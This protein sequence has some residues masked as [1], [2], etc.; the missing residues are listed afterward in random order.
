MATVL[1]V[2]EL[3]TDLGHLSQLRLAIEVALQEGHTV[4]LAARELHR[5][6]EVMGD[7]P[8]TYLQAPFK[9]NQ[10]QRGQ[11]HYRSYTHLIAQQCFASGEELRMYV[12]AWRALFDLARPHVVLFEHSPTALIAAHAY[13]FR[14]VLVGNGFT[15][16]AVDARAG[17]PFLPFPTTA[18]TPESDAAL[19]L[20]D[21]Q[22]LACINQTL[23]G[24]GLSK[25]DSLGA[26]YAQADATFLMTW[27]ELDHFG[28]RPGQR[29]LGIEP[30]SPRAAA[31][32]PPGPGSKVFGYLHPIPALEQLLQALLAYPIR[33]LL[34]VRHLHPAL[35]ARYTSARLQFIDHP[36]DLSTVASQADW[37]INL[38]NHSTAATFALAGIPQL[39]I[40]LHQEHL[41]LARRLVAQGA[42]A[43][44]FQDQSGYT[45]AVDAMQHN[46][47]IR[48]QAQQLRQQLTPFEALQTPDFMRSVYAQ[49][50]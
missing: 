46:A 20:D 34:F 38:G 26:I 29:Y 14:K 47:G 9:Q 50:V 3:G 31:Q 12:S 19:A 35:R 32:W 13:P 2:W 10:V 7:M 17:R 28:A 36:V 16:P 1:C 24:M 33:A 42:A 22:L 40:P 25:M 4:L 44:A 27:P 6:R 39:L 21:D 37:V 48:H 43:M 45:Q 41:F 18:S 15:A 49:F 30:P 23:Q 11:D 5:A 8:I